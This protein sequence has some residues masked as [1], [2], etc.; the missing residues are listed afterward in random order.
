MTGLHI[1]KKPLNSGDRYYVYAWRGGPRIHVENGRY[2]VATREILALQ[3]QE[4]DKLKF[5]D[6]G[7]LFEELISEYRVSPDFTRLALSTQRDYRLWL[8]RI[9]ERFGETPID[10]FEDRRMRGDIL[11]W[12]DNWSDQPRT[13]DKASVMLSTILGWGVER[14]KLRIN[15]AAK[16]K[17]LHNVNKSDRIW[18]DEHWEAFAAAEPP[19]HLHN[20]LIFASLTGLRLGD[21]VTVTWDQVYPTAIKVEKTRKRGGRAIIPILPELRAWMADKE[22]V[23][24]IL[25]NSRGIP[26]SSSG[27]GCVFQ[28]KKPPGF[29]R[30][31]H[32]LRGTFATRLIMAGLTDDQV[33]MVLAWTSK[34]VSTLRAR[35]VNE[36]RVILDLA[37]K[38]QA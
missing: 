11:K 37:S 1:V 15:I 26:W 2:P 10:V 18:E 12:R 25:K 35:Y 21:L 7:P 20:A 22:R 27:L 32:D 16:I 24:T 9:S 29:E 8:N 30:T 28:R 31:F 33:S 14:G 5:S 36:E 34:R 3:Q 17:Q 23:G 4:I 38:L 19:E 13:A 6:D